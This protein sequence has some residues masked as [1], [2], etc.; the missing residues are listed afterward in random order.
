M[1]NH[2]LT[3]M[4]D[5]NLVRVLAKQT[6]SRIGRIDFATVRAGEDAV[7]R[8]IREAA[9]DGTRHLIVDAVADEDL[10][11]IGLGSADL[12]L[13]TGGSGLALGLPELFARQGML[14]RRDDAAHLPHTSGPAVVLAGSCSQATLEQVAWMRERRPAF[15]LDTAKLDRPG[16][17]AAAAVA[18]AEA[19]LAAGPILISASAPPAEVA[20]AQARFGAQIA[21]ERIEGVLA[22]VASALRDRGVRRFVVAGGETSGAVVRALG[23]GALRIGP[24]IDPGVPWTASLGEPALALALKSGNFGSEDFFL[25]AIEVAP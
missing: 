22:Q 1:Q 21:G 20:A 25:R 12:R 9:A 13:I 14:G 18:W 10:V 24:Q 16:E 7:R 3:P 6:R 17:L 19:Q 8:A 5:A 11:A 15:A 2:P 23:V 4:S